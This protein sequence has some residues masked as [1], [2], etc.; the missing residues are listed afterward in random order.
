MWFLSRYLF[1]NEQVT[2]IPQLQ[3]PLLLWSVTFLAVKP[4]VSF[5]KSL[6]LMKSIYL[7]WSTVFGGPGPKKKGGEGNTKI[8]EYSLWKK[9]FTVVLFNLSMSHVPSM[10]RFVC[11]MALLFCASDGEYLGF[12]LFSMFCLLFFKLSCLRRRKI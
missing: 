3:F 10:P 9:D 8:H 11:C 6:D 2:K 12:A 7:F 5:W 4:L 1:L